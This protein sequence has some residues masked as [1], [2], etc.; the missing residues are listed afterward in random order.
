MDITNLI[1]P[2]QFY[3]GIP[4]NLNGICNIYPKKLKDIAKIGIKNFYTYLNIFTLELEDIKSFLAQA[5][6]TEEISKFQFHLLNAKN[7]KV[8]YSNVINAFQF[9]LQEENIIILYDSGAIVLG[10]IKDERII[11]EEEFNAICEIVSMQHVVKDTTEQALDN[12]SDAVA[13]KIIKQIKEGQ[14]KRN[15]NKQNSNLSFLDLVDALAAKG[16]GLNALNIWEL[17][18][19]AFNCQFK[20]MQWIEDYEH[21]FQSLLAGAKKESVNLEHWIRPM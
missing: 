15:K 4:A 6:I 2:E 20:R 13:A 12:P 5:G 16:N 8:Y 10:D 9:F 18:Y 21:G 14:K 7:D 3:Y 1:N 11:R 19:Y 17:T